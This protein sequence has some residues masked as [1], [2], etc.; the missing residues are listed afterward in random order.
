[1][2]AVNYST[3]RSNLKEYCDKVIDNHETLIITRKNEENVVLMGLEEYN[4][5]MN[6]IKILKNPKYFKDL[7]KSLKQVEEGK[8]VIKK[9]ADVIGEK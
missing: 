2:L 9:V 4:D 5:M 8:I 7:S 1:M 6:T 3:V